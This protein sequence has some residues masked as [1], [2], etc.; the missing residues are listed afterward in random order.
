[1]AKK[2]RRRILSPRARRIVRKTLRWTLR[3]FLSLI[4]VILVVLVLVLYSSGFLHVVLDLGLG[5]YN[6][7]IPGEIHIG[8]VEGRL[9]DHLVLGDIYLQDG[10]GR[11]LVAARELSL[12]WTPWDLLHKG[13][14]VE[15]IELSDAQV[16][17]V[18]GGGFGDLAIPGPSKPPRTTVAPNLPIDLKVADIQIRGVDLYKDSGETIVGGLR[19]SARDLAWKGL[20][21]HLKIDDA[22]AALP[23]V[24]LEA[25][26]LEAN[27]AEPH[28]G[29]TGLIT[30]DLAIAELVRVDLDADDLTG[31]VALAID[32]RRGALAA[33]LGGKI[34]EKLAAAPAD[35]SVRID[36]RGK[37]GDMQV[38]VEALVPGLAELALSVSGNPLGAPH[39]QLRGRLDA[40]LEGLLPP[41]IGSKLGY[42]R[43]TFEAR[44]TGADWQQLSAEM[45]LGC[46]DCGA[47]SGLDVKVLARHD[48]ILSDSS[49]FAQL[50]GAGMALTA[51]IQAGPRGPEAGRWDLRIPDVAVPLGVARLFKDLPPIDGALAT[52]GSCTGAPLRCEGSFEVGDFR[53]YKVRVGSVQGHLHG[54]PLAKIPTA[55]AELSVR[56]IV[57]PDYRFAG[58]EV[59]ADV[60]P[61]KDVAPDAEHPDGVLEAAIHA[62]AWVRARDKGD[63]A[64]VAARVRP[65][66]PLTV[67][68]EVLD[69]HMRGLRAL[70]PRPA[71][72]E[73]AGR[74]VEIAGLRLLAAGGEI[75]VDGHADLDGR[76]DLKAKI[77]RVKLAPLAAL[78]PSLRG[79]VGGSVTAKISL[80]GP[81]HT[82]SLSLLLGGQKLRFRDGAIGDLDVAVD[83]GGGKGR[84]A[85]GLVGPMAERFAV[86]A[87]TPLIADLGRG[88]FGLRPGDLHF[89]VDIKQFRLVSLHP[90]L[91]KSMAPR[92]LVDVQLAVDGPADKPSTKL[93]VRGRDLVYSNEPPASLAVDFTQL[94]DQDAVARI[95]AGRLGGRLRVNAPVLPLR[96]DLLDGGYKWRPEDPHEVTIVAR[97]I[98][99]W[100]QLNAFMPGHDFAGRIEVEGKLAGPVTAP[101]LQ[102]L[103]KGDGLRYRDGT[104]G[105][106]RIN[107][108][109]QGHSA[110]VDLDLH[111]DV[112]RKITLHAEA[113]LR[114]AVM[115]REFVWLKDQPHVLD[116]DIQGFD[117]AGLKRLGLTAAWE[118]TVDVNAKL[119]GSATVP[120]LGVRTHLKELVWK[121]R[122]VGTVRAEVD[123]AKQQVRA[124]VDAQLGN[125]TVK[126]EATAPLA[127]NLGDRKVKW[128][129]NGQHDVEIRVDGLD[130]TMLAPLGRVPEEALLELSMIAHAKGNLADFSAD[131]EAH[132]QMGHKLIGGAPVHIS[133]RAEPKAQSL[134][135]SV[136]PHKWA[137][138]IH[139]EAKAAADILALVRKK[140]K[141]DDIHFTA[142][143]IAPR[144][145]TRFAQAFVPRDFYDIN[146]ILQA[147]L[148]ASGT[149]GAPDV[150]GELH[151][152]K[153]S[154]SVLAMQQRIR[155]VE[156]D[157]K[158]SGRTIVVEKLTAV[159]GKG[160]V[161]A[162][163]RVDIPH[164]GGMKVVGD[165]KLSKFPVVRPGLPQMQVDTH[166]KANVV[167]S[168]EETDV[169]VNVGGTKVYVTGYTVDAPKQIPESAAVKFKDEKLHVPVATS[170][171][172]DGEVSAENETKTP[173]TEGDPKAAKRFAVNI[174]LTDPVDIRGPGVEMLWQGAVA[175]TRDGDKRDV[176]GK[177]T[178]KEGRL[179]LLGNRFKIQSGQV[180]LPEDEDTVDPFINV[181]AT[182]STTIAEV[183][184]TFKGRLTRPELIFSSEPSMSQSQILTLLLTGSPDA[185]EADEQRVLAQAAALLATFQ[186]P[187]LSAFLS[188]RLGID[189]VGLSFGDDV[190]QPILS[191]G[192]RLSKNIYVETAYKVNADPRRSNK[193]EARVEYQFKP[194]WT[195]ETFFGDAAVGGLDVF[196]R[197]LFGKPKRLQ[198]HAGKPAPRGTGASEAPRGGS[199][200]GAPS[201]GGGGGGAH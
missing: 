25:L 116:A 198:E 183:K 69:V 102:L 63:R 84:A 155:K 143:M 10:N 64:K 85:V 190:N 67:F 30:T 139:V 199:S 82:P 201:G 179:D 197:K 122:R 79:Q 96:I 149:V 61:S 44:I 188:S 177:L 75:A 181:V 58:A 12:R 193:I 184:A 154:I 151:M 94:A 5:F 174:K 2:P 146:G 95:D 18:K 33:K 74:R 23:V 171:G 53:G 145:D 119:R 98:D 135:F 123:Y 173:K 152:H 60:G 168:A 136:G 126:V 83:V 130:R 160:T 87:E 161:A 50:V 117:L 128:D 141:A 27:Y 186:N 187:Q 156:L 100:R 92:G 159:S 40:Q 148:H 31:H 114:I 90:W 133:V 189:H 49:A 166:V 48:A 52:R 180:T 73:L 54:E 164:G 65:G 13:V 24:G 129:E 175:A 76:S 196:W 170:E 104:L 191:V 41:E 35:P 51:E 81:A 140:A 4:L 11:V 20:V 89:A 162:S 182:T 137:G 157:V 107:T 97:D 36:A 127:M 131:L 200:S 86:A 22:A 39:L 29:L 105:K 15:K 21:A 71:R 118:G 9:A 132:G 112:A 134:K 195:V 16:H 110:T 7:R 93:S 77:D 47:A 113:P 109:L 91:K 62:E 185:T 57:V 28:L 38:G 121:S 169:N 37:A 43:P 88:K 26:A 150:R 115:K 80:Q 192:K 101:D 111:G 56:D 138:E 34:G 120:E 167:S 99:V 172:P 163:A 108:R 124:G 142:S 165:L 68:L 70:L 42:V 103:V 1:M 153:G 17:L 72:I 32:G 125:G 147:E 55:H 178:A 106:L 59:S 176:T 8:R 19:L 3:I 78:V 14:T 46:V 6:A 144:F 194:H 66:P 45:R 158:A